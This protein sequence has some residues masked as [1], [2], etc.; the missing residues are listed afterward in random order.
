MK[1]V[2]PEVIQHEILNKI[3]ASGF[4]ISKFTPKFK[5]YLSVRSKKHEITCGFQ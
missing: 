1:M 2:V 5:Y 3:F 4:S